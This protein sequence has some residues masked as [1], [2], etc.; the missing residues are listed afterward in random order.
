MY[1]ILCSRRFLALCG[2]GE[3][4]ESAVE[5]ESGFEA[6]SRQE[7]GEVAG[8]AVWVVPLIWVA[9]LPCFASDDLLGGRS[10]SLA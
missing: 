3:G 2:R 5:I 1:T 7:R 10:P 6:C 8:D 9:P 4:V